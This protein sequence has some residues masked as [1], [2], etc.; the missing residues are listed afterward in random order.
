MPPVELTPEQARRIQLRAQGLLG[1][2]ATTHDGPGLRGDPGARRALGA[3][4]HLGA[5]QLDT[6]SVL[7]RSHELVAYARLGAVGRSSVEHAY[8][9]GTAAFEYWSHAACVLP[10][11]DWP[12]YAFRRR[13]YERRGHHWHRT[14]E[15]ASKDVLARLRAEGPLTA[16]GL[17]GAKKG[18]EWFDRTDQKIAAEFLLA[19]GEVVCTRR[20]GWR[21]V[22]DLAERAIP[23]DLRAVDLSDD[24]CITTLVTRAGRALGVATRAD[25]ADYV[26]VRGD[27]VDTVIEASGLVPVSVPGWSN[28]WAHPDALGDQP[29]GRHRTSLLSPFDSL[30]W[31]RKRTQRMF[32]FDHRLEAYVPKDKRVHGY[33]T[34]PLLAGGHLIGRVDPA[35]EGGTLV[36][37]KASLEP[38][39]VNTRPKADRAITHLAEALREAAEWVGC[40]S[41]RVERLTPPALAAPLAT[42]LT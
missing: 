23:A 9:N 42:A 33:F 4:R 39:A 13:A 32:A 3:L 30:V 37:R 19:T 8:W 20:V 10:I 7:A 5:V 12:L 35:R 40:H 14:P 24:E 38:A 41:I 26:R 36:A 25:L 34:M 2:V 29:R 27:Q 18:G 22:Y 31:D 15:Q 17:G 1:R 21:R 11:E 16:T 6:I 28:T